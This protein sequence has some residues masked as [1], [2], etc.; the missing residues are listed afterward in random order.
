M[1]PVGA[2]YKRSDGIVLVDN[3]RCIGCRF[4]MAACPYSARVFNWGKPEPPVEKHDEVYSPE[5]S[6]PSVVSNF[7]FSVDSP[8]LSREHEE[9]KP[10]PIMA[11]VPVSSPFFRNFLRS[12][13]SELEFSSIT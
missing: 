10:A 1:C 11:Q 5:T 7:T 4:C 9:I 6:S 13:F 12:E 8:D 3:V 2:T